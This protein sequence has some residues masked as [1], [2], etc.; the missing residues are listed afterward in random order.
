MSATPPREYLSIEIRRE[1]LLDAAVEVV[2][3]EGAAAL[4][5]R[6]VAARAGVA[7]RV[8]SYAFG[9]KEALEVALLRRESARIMTAVWQEELAAASFGE[10]VRRALRAYA[11]DL[12][13]RQTVHRVVAE[14]TATA[15]SPAAEEVARTEA[16]AYLDAI[17][18][19]IARWEAAAGRT[20]D[21]PRAVVAA[22]ILAAADGVTRWWLATGDDGRLGD[23]VDVLASAFA[24]FDDD[25]RR[26]A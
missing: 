24:R 26:P 2:A 10:A 7:H 19:S 8:V 12:R 4:S 14:L 18:D 13:A 11:E 25:R 1:R 20:I 9:S 5:L 17:G 3:D 6:S 22:A 21:A 16:E 15:R 23:V